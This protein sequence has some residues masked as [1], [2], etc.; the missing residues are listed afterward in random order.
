[1]FQVLSSAIKC[2]FSD[3]LKMFLE[4]YDIS[5]ERHLI[6]NSES[7]EKVNACFLTRPYKQFVECEEVGT[8]STYRCPTC[9][10]CDDCKCGP[11]MEEV[12]RKEESVISISLTKV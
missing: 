8:K 2:Y 5:P 3:Q 12:S 9:R 7:C 11:V 10:K 4:G 6:I 1:M